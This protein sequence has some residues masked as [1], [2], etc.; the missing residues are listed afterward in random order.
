MFNSLRA[1][2]AARRFANS[3][4]VAHL[5]TP[6]S[7]LTVT[8][9]AVSSPIFALYSS[10]LY[11]LQ[12]RF[13]ALYAGHS[14]SILSVSRHVAFTAVTF[15][16]AEPIWAALPSRPCCSRGGDVRGVRTG[17]VT[18]ISSEFSYFQRSSCAVSPSPANGR[19]RLALR[20]ELVRVSVTR[21]R[22]FSTRV[23]VHD[24]SSIDFRDAPFKSRYF[25][26]R[27][28]FE[29]ANLSAVFIKFYIVY[30]LG[31]RSTRSA[32]M[33]R[34]LFPRKSALQCSRSVWLEVVISENL[35]QRLCNS[36]LSRK[37]MRNEE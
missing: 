4:P 17:R 7:R 32:E 24:L 33:A 6:A 16:F 20:M 8:H 25:S 22:Y 10:S 26:A 13:F 23:G 28:S 21:T 18:A 27:R 14:G 12:P 34:R 29:G 35:L 11:V 31:F 15:T 1:V 3:L 9:L 30:L 2:F 37:R 36:L 19:A 5:R